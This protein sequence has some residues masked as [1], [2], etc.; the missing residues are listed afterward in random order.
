MTLRST[1]QER[2]K[3]QIASRQDTMQESVISDRMVPVL[4][5]INEIG[6]IEKGTG[7][8]QSNTIYGSDGVSPCVNAVNYKEPIK[9][10]E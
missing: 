5:S 3:S 2:L 1:D 4:S 8:H 10:L 6:F 7:K 9:I